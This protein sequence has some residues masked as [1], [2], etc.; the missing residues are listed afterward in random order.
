MIN[1]NIFLPC[2]Y[3]NSGSFVRPKKAN[4]GIDCLQAIK[5][6]YGEQKSGVAG[7]NTDELFVL[8]ADNKQTIV[9]MVGAE[10]INQK[11]R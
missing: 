4:L 6:R 1:N 5:D 11:Q 7:V 3:P 10:K 9:E 2:R 8:D